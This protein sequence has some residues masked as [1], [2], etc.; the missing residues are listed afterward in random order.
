MRRSVKFAPLVLM[1]AVAMSCSDSTAPNQR[2]VATISSPSTG[3]QAFAGDPVTF[4]GSATDP[5][6]GSLTGDALLWQSDLDGVLGNGTSVTR[7]DLSTGT[8]QITLAA[9][10]PAGGNGTA[11]ISVSIVENQAPTVAITSPADGTQVLL[12]A[13]VTLV[14]SAIDTE[15]GALGGDDVTWESSLDGQLGTGTQLATSS[16]SQGTH[17]IT[18]T[19]EDSRGLEGSNGIELEVLANGLPAVTIDQPATGSNF[20]DTDAISFVGSATDDEDGALTGSSLVWNS[21]L[22]GDFATGEAPAALTLSAGIHLVTLTATDAQGQEGTNSVSIT[23]E[24][25]Q[26]DLYEDDNTSGDAGTIASGEIQERNIRP[27]AD[28]D[29]LTFT[30]TES[31]VVVLETRG[32]PGDDTVLEL[33]DDLLN[34]IEEDD[35]GG[36]N[37]NSRIARVCGTNELPAGTYFARVTSFE[38]GITISDYEIAYTSAACATFDDSQPGYDLEVRYLGTP[39][40]ASQQQTFEDAAARWAELIIGDVADEIVLEPFAPTCFGEQLD[41]IFEQLDD[42]VVFARVIALDGPGGILG[43]A[44]P[45]FIRT[46]TGFPLVGLMSFDEADVA[47]LEAGGAFDVVILHEMGHVVGFGT[48][49]DYLGLLVDPTF[50]TGTINDTHFIGANALTAFDDMGG[51]SYP[52]AK[53]PVEN[54][55]VNFGGG[56]LNGHW[57]ESVFNNELMSPALNS[58]VDPISV[59]TVESLRDLGYDVDETAAD[60]YT[61]PGTPL[62]AGGGTPKLHFGDDMLI[63]QK[64]TPDRTGRLRPLGGGEEPNDKDAF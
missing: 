2:P 29:W 31:S 43:Q 62:V 41:P 9:A 33:Y 54:D 21:S 4:V 28:E 8:H 38:S 56:S 14:G 37:S 64:L 53:V 1:T 32:E 48:L 16:L 15:D 46:P 12:G 63:G 6:S 51:A 26:G 58:A 50:P 3:S 10:D 18:L 61:L 60:A 7:S 19:A 49:W 30:L 47:N 34:L 23:V 22:D 59:L 36:L 17:T 52:D 24:N 13:E 39:P 55:N 20:L 44:G 5:E 35:D 25:T 57:R 11:S 42:L 40:S 27:A 45:C